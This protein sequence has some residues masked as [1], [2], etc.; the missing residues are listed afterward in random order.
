[1]ATKVQRQDSIIS[2]HSSNN[3]N[4]TSPNIAK[5]IVVATISYLFSPHAINTYAINTC[6]QVCVVQR[7]GWCHCYFK[8]ACS[9]LL[10]CA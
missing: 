7:Q 8:G 9:V 4:D 10:L 2:M 3:N 6:Y 1:M 5:I